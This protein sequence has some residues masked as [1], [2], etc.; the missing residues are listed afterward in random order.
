MKG[1][2]LWLVICANLAVLVA[3][4]FVYP[5]LMVAPG[6]LVQGHAELATDCFAC[7]TPLRGATADRCV[8]CHALPDIG[9]RTTKGVTIVHAKPL[10]ASFHQELSDPNCMACHSDHAGP[11]VQAWK[12]ATFDHDK[13]FPLDKDHNATCVTCHTGNN[14]QQYTCYGCHEHTPARMLAKHREEGVTERL[15]D[16]VRCHRSASDEGNDQG[17]GERG[18]GRR[19][20][21]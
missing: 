13:F 11:K 21:D 2:W 15:D 5:H 17:R 3:L 18:K 1:R 10:K 16:C 7:H 6:A 8:A 4:V 14:Y 12:P 20:K 19:E 9:L